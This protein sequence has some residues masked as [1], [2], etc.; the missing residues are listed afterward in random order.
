MK[1]TLCRMARRK[2]SQG[3]RRRK[4]VTRKKSSQSNFVTAL[5]KL[6]GLKQNDQRQAISMA[7]GKFIRQ[8]VGHIK[9][10]KR[11]KLS[12]KVRKSLQKHKAKLRLLTKPQT[13]V[14]KHRKILSQKGGGFLNDIIRSIPVVGTVV[15]L[16]EDN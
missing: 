4:K 2:T 5:H 3:R 1:K 6:R 11:A 13:P 7:N 15:R 8:F 12:P 9:K 10:L 16:I 14:T